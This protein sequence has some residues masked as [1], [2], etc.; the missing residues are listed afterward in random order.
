MYY[1]IEE[2]Y[3]EVFY[4]DATVTNMNDVMNYKV[5]LTNSLGSKFPLLNLIVNSEPKPCDFFKSGPFLIISSNLK[6][7]FESYKC[8]FEYYDVTLEHHDIFYNIG[9]YYFAHLVCEKNFLDENNSSYSL[10]GEYFDDIEKIAIEECALD[11]EPIACLS[12]SFENIVVV[13][14]DLANNMGCEKINGIELT[15]VLSLS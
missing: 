8:K 1:R 15:P 10:D 5:T 2:S 4:T 6:K 3:D 7:I 14:E 13:R 9:N 11:N 12:K